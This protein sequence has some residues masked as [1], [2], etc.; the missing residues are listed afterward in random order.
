LVSKKDT[1]VFGDTEFE[2]RNLVHHVGAVALEERLK[3]S[4]A[5]K[6]RASTAPGASSPRN[7]KGTARKRP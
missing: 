2:A 1:E 6:D 5:M 7:S 3:K 4:S